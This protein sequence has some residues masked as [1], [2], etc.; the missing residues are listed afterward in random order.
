M[1]SSSEEMRVLGGAVLQPLVA[2]VLAFASFELLL[3]DR[4][5]QTLAGG[6]PGDVTD[7]ALSVAIGA[8]IVAG[9]ITVLGALP[10]AV[11]LMKRR[12]VTLT[13]TLLFG[14][15]FGNLPYFLIAVFA[16]GTYGIAGFVRGVAFSSLLGL[17]GAAVFWL[18]A[19]RPDKIRHN[20]AAS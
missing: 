18:I 5:G 1:L 14:L 7:S 9:L 19:I 2:G 6:Y 3:L 10:T 17:G 11:F 20:P 13:K 12:Y 15:G 8:S 4:Q 16:G